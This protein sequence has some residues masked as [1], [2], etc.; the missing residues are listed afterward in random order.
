[1]RRYSRDPRWITLRHRGTCFR[2]GA[3]MEPGDAAW[4]YPTTRDLFCTKTLC[5]KAE[6]LD[7][8]SA[9]GDEEGVPFAR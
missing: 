1:M 9:V 6:R 2:C 3:P 5:G 7:F 4:Y 8:L